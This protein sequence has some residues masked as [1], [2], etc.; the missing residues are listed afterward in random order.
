M[1]SSEKFQKEI[2]YLQMLRLKFTI[3]AFIFAI[4][5]SCTGNNPLHQTVKEETPPKTMGNQTF[6][7]PIEEEVYVPIYSDIYHRN[8]NSKVLLTATLSIR[9]TSRTQKLY[10]KQVDYFDSAGNFVRDYLKEPIFLGPL[11]T[12][13]Y[14]IDEEDESGG[15]GANFMILWG[16]E[17]PIKPIF[18]AVM[19]GG[20]GS[21]GIT[22]TTEGVSVQKKEITPETAPAEVDSIQ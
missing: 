10:I 15:S 13:D 7:F 6:D 21:Q 14:V 8:R 5:I 1:F 19:V 4:L 2:L 11:E 3:S 9:N 20:I 22:F 17:K 12:I 18:Q 16:S